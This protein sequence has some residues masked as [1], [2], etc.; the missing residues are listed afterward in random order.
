MALA[1]DTAAATPLRGGIESY[2]KMS[3]LFLQCILPRRESLTPPWP[4]NSA[5]EG[6][7]LD[8]N[9]RGEIRRRSCRKGRSIVKKANRLRHRRTFRRGPA[10]KLMSAGS[11]PYLD[12]RRL[13]RYL[14][15]KSCSKNLRM[16][17]TGIAPACRPTSIPFLKIDIVGIAVTRKRPAK[18][19]SS[20]VL[21]LAT[22]T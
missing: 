21:T 13:H 7:P 20:S 6:I 9:F 2:P 22:R 17:G 19:E 14:A 1:A 10:P 18:L 12:C 3:R 15:T 4:V 11:G 5:D 8:Q 16:A